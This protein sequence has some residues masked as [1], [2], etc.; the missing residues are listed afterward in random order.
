[1]RLTRPRR[2]VEECGAMSEDDHNVRSLSEKRAEPNESVVRILKRWLREA[3]AGEIH[4]V[5]LIGSRNGGGIRR[6]VAGDY[7]E[8][9]IVFQVRANQMGHDG[10]VEGARSTDASRE[11]GRKG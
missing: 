10:G 11:G 6:V 1:M 7:D 4:S 8:Q 9:E 5:V 2:V 3:E